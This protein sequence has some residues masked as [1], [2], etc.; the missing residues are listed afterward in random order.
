MSGVGIILWKLLKRMELM[1][2]VLLVVH[3]MTKNE[4][5][6]WQQTVKGSVDVQEVSEFNTFCYLLA[7]IKYGCL[8]DADWWLK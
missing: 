4:L 8:D 3:L 5:W 7:T 1:A 6:P 2:V